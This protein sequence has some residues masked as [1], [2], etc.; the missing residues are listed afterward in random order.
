MSSPDV[1]I[2]LVAYN[3]EQLLPRL[4]AALDQSLGV[5]FEVLVVD[6]A[7]RDGSASW[8]KKHRPDWRLIENTQNVGFGRANNQLLPLVKGQHVLL[9]NTDAFV[10]AETLRI[11][12]SYLES[13]PEVGLL[14]VQ[15]TGDD[16]T[17]Q[18][19][20]RFFP[21]PWNLFLRRSGLD[22]LASNSNRVDLPEWRISVP[23]ECDWVPGCYYLIQGKCLAEVGLFDERFFLY[24]EEV[25]HC[26]RVKAAGFKIHCTPDTKVVHLGGASAQSEGA[27]TAGGRQLLTL[28]IESELLYIRK[29]FGML[30]FVLHIALQSACNARRSIHQLKMLWSCVFRTRAGVRATR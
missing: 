20:A 5:S 18:P 26:R 13:H 22:R 25:D 7:S 27:L 6:N 9:L 21:T 29:H 17:A 8:I 15:L 28:Q 14:G 23:T 12:L 30:G 1:S 11:S 2:L 24:Y 10:Q 16:G 4:A 19:S 3:C